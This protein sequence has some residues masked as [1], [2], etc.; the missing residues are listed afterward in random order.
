MKC[1]VCFI[2]RWHRYYEKHFGGQRMECQNNIISEEFADFIVSNNAY[3]LEGVLQD[4]PQICADY[5][6]SE[7]TILYVPM[8]D[9]THL[10]RKLIP[11]GLY[12]REAR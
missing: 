5:A 10:F 3:D 11:L 9:A 8:E 12:H 7:F 4:N 6:D 1:R 2:A